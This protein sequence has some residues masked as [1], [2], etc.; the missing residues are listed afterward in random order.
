MASP[1]RENGYTA[2]ANELLEA[3]ARIRIPG[4]SRQVL[5]VLFRKTYG[6]Q[7]KQDAVSLSQFAVMTG[8]K[9][10]N[11]VRALNK[12]VDMGIVIKKDTT[13]TTIYRVDKDFDHWKPLS[14]RIPPVSLTIPKVVSKTIHTKE[15]KK[16]NTRAKARTSMKKNR[17]GSYRE[18]SPQ[19]SYDESIDL[20]TGEA[21]KPKERAGVLPAYKE[22]VEWSEKRRGFKFISIPKQYKAFKE[23]KTFGLMPSDLKNRWLDIE[24]DKFYT[25]K[26]FD[27]TTVVYS[28]NKKPR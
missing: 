8:L 9:R 18:D 14:K 1:Q 23:A 5:D 16:L 26:G 7:K 3:L 13:H 22:L 19:D 24:G 25:E 21:I 17:M 2:I 11:V 15:I 27:W 12:L 10:P 20:D 28:F 4:E 6:Y